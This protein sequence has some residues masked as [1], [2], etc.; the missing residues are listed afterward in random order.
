MLKEQCRIEEEQHLCE[1]TELKSCTNITDWLRFGEISQSF[2]R[3]GVLEASCYD[4][5]VFC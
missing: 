5:Y 1:I 2:M 3:M 4:G